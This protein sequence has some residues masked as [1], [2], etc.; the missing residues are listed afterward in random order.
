M[1][2]S[3]ARV[4]ILCVSSRCISCYFTLPSK[5]LWFLSATFSPEDMW[6]AV[7][8]CTNVTVWVLAW[9]DAELLY[10]PTYSV[11]NYALWQQRWICWVAM[12]I[13]GQL[14][15]SWSSSAPKSKATRLPSGWT[16]DVWLQSSFFLFFLRFPM[17]TVTAQGWKSPEWLSH[18]DW[19]RALEISHKLPPHSKEQDKSQSS[20]VSSLQN[21][22]YTFHCFFFLRFCCS[23]QTESFLSDKNI[24]K[25]P[26]AHC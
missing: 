18:G 10:G 16:L 19:D 13:R 8:F 6:R 20:W 5:Q 12:E 14:F 4:Y 22:L 11:G 1:W 24:K 15:R 3:R 7:V 25:T 23:R 2:P 26:N 17:G 21:F 9:F